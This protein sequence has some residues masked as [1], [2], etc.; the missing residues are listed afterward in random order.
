M[1]R[2]TALILLSGIISVAH[3]QTDSTKN[4]Y[5]LFNRTPQKQMR[6]MK[7]D[8]P[9]VTESAY[10]VDAGHFQIESDVFKTIRNKEEDLITIQNFYQLANIKAGISN[11]IDLQ[12]VIESYVEN[13][14]G[15][16]AHTK[17]HTSSGFGDMTVRIKKNLWGNDGGNTALAVMPFITI[18]TSQFSANN[19]LSGGLI[20]PF[21]AELN[22]GWSFSAQLQL[23]LE[24][25]AEKKH[26]QPLFLNSVTFG[27]KLSD[28]FDVF[29]ESF[30]SFEAAQSQW[31]I[32]LDGGLIYSL[33]DNFK[34][35]AGFNYG[36]MK[37]ADKVYFL[38]FSF[39]Y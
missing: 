1:K 22:H 30:Y 14:S 34:L 7:T 8:R 16:S 10:T 20:F 23:D 2:I 25:G 11:S 9:D 12:L 13:K 4:G 24:K 35:D 36:L 28:K 26:Y 21:A 6:E 18:P 3:S 17:R 38:G 31:D 19:N 33:S 39:R 29:L 37:S 32:F 27:K 15:T 5:H